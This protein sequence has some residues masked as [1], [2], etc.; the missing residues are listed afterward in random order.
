[1]IAI[2][3]VVA[4]QNTKIVYAP[5]TSHDW[6]DLSTYFLIAVLFLVFFLKGEGRTLSKPSSTK[7]KLK[8]APSLGA[9]AAPLLLVLIHQAQVL[10][11]YDIGPGADLAYITVAVLL[12]ASSSLCGFFYCCRVSRN[13]E[14]TGAHLELVVKQPETNPTTAVKASQLYTIRIIYFS[15][16]FLNSGSLLAVGQFLTPF[17]VSRGL[18]NTMSRLA[19]LFFYCLCLAGSAAENVFSTSSAWFPLCAQGG[20]VFASVL[21]MAL[22]E[23]YAALWVAAGLL[24]ISLRMVSIV[25]RSPAR[26]VTDSV[27]RLRVTVN[28]LGEML[29]CLVLGPTLDDEDPR[30]FGRVT[31]VVQVVALAIMLALWSVIWRREKKSSERQEARTGCRV[32]EVNGI[33]AESQSVTEPGTTTTWYEFGTADRHVRQSAVP[34]S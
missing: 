23:N 32:R 25:E 31:S 19:T 21:M 2:P 14:V 1:M 6:S 26:D 34:G 11:S 7:M 13:P 12:V 16:M 17:C 24:G 4:I 10:S 20:A 9:C 29:L 33:P 30:A 3:L 15:V 22:P 18:G 5:A 27:P 8:L 28:A